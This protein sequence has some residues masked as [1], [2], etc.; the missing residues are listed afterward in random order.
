MPRNKR[1]RGKP[2]KPLTQ[3]HKDKI[4]LALRNKERRVKRRQV[5][6][7]ALSRTATI[8]GIL[9]TSSY[10]VDRL[11]RTQSRLRLEANRINTNRLGS[12]YR[13]IGTGLKLGRY[14][15]SS[16]EAKL[17]EFR[18][19]GKDKKK[20]KRKRKGSTN[21]SKDLVKKALITGAIGVSLRSGVQGLGYLALKRQQETK[22][23]NLRNIKRRNNIEDTKFLYRM[24]R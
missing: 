9:Q 6:D 2:R 18:K 12:A 10:A 21:V 22:D 8:A 14:L 1:L 17:I 11:A 13:G 4:S 5:I 15:F 3:A 23:I 16:P 19:R 20:R 7:K 24:V